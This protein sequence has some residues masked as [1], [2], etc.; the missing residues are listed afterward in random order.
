M[1]QVLSFTSKARRREAP[2]TSNTG[3]SYLTGELCVCASE[4]G[5]VRVCLRFWMG[6]VQTT[7]DG[8]NDFSFIQW[9]SSVNSKWRSSGMGKKTERPALGGWQEGRWREFTTPWHRVF[10]S[11]QLHS[12]TRTDPV[13]G[14]MVLEFPRETSGSQLRPLRDPQLL[15]LNPKTAERTCLQSKAREREGEGG[16]DVGKDGKVWTLEVVCVKTC[17]NRGGV[18][19]RVIAADK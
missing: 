14:S 2:F 13:S 4:C 3:A 10:P 6:V 19:L 17:Y 9:C 8:K 7:K 12:V 18:F 5:C 16:I 11:R 15:E 1:G